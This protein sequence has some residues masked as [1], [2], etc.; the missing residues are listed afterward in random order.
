MFKSLCLAC[1]PYLSHPPTAL[2]NTTIWLAVLILFKRG[3]VCFACWVCFPFPEV[4][5][6]KIFVCGDICCLLWFL[7]TDCQTNISC[8]WKS[9]K[10]FFLQSSD[11]LINLLIKNVR[12]FIDFQRNAWR[13]MVTNEHLL[14]WWKHLFYK[15]NSI[16]GDAAHLKSQFHLK[17]QVFI[18]INSI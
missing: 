5:A 7:H 3:W 15:W 10:V 16:T 8:F 4:L 14:P 2:N 12:C 11:M 9:L 1:F 13:L 18:Q 17:S 6:L